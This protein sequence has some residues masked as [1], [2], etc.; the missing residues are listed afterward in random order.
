M[1]TRN[2]RAAAAGVLGFT[3]AAG[4]LLGVVWARKSPDVPEPVASTAVAAEEAEEDRGRESRRRG[5]MVERV[6]LSAEQQIQVDSVVGHARGMMRQLREDY[7]N[8]YGELIESTRSSIKDVLTSEQ[9]A[10][11]EALLADFDRR[12]ARDGARDGERPETRERRSEPRSPGDT[13]RQSEEPDRS[14]RDRGQWSYS[15]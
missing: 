5:L 6:G 7:R 2:T 14:E 12:R 3:L 13:P 15:Y 8:G 10:E 4:V 1:T 9:A 11:Y